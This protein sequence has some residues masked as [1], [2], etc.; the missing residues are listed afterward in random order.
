MAAI[1]AMWL[2]KIP[3]VLGFVIMMAATSS[4]MAFATVS[5]CSRPSGPLSSWTVE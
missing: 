1:S 3:S 2:S 4:S 5:G